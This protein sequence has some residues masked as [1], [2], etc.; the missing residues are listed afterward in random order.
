MATEKAVNAVLQALLP[1]LTLHDSAAVTRA[2]TSIRAAAPE[3]RVLANALYVFSKVVL[4]TPDSVACFNNVVN[5][6]VS[7]GILGHAELYDAID[8]ETHKL[9]EGAERGR[10]RHM[11]ERRMRTRTYY[12]QKR[13]NLF[14]EENE[15]YAKAIVLFWEVVFEHRTKGVVEALLALVGQFSLDSNRVIE[16][17]LMAAAEVVHENIKKSGALPSDH[18]LPQLFVELLDKF[19]RDH[20]A[21]VVGAM[22]LTHHAVEPVGFDAST[23]VSAAQSI[24]TV[25]PGGSALT[26]TRG[27]PERKTAESFLLLVLVLMREG[28]LTV[29]DIWHNMSPR[30]DRELV[31][32]FLVYEQQLER[33]S[34][35]VSSQNAARPMPIKDSSPIFVRTGIGASERDI[36]SQYK[37]VTAGPF[38]QYTCQKLEF[39]V[40]LINACRWDDAMDAILSLGVNGK[41]ID[42]AAQ[43]A[44]GR[45]LASFV[46][47][48]LNPLLCKHFPG[49]YKENRAL[50]EAITKLGGRKNR[51][52]CPVQSIEEFLDEN[53]IDGPGAVVLQMLQVLGPHARTSPGL[54]HALCRILR[55]E[56]RRK[57][58]AVTIMQEVVLPASSLLQSN[59]GLVNEIWE[60][61]RHWSHADRWLLYGHLQNVVSRNCAAYQ[62]VSSRASYE[63]RYVLK[64]L[65]SE[66]HKQHL[67]VITKIT[68]GQS[69]PAFSAAVDRIQGYPPDAVTISPVVEACQDCSELAVDVLLYTIVDRM[70]DS[71]KSRL[72]EDG[73]NIA[74][75]YATLSLFL[76]LCLRKLR[77]SSMQIEGVLS[78][79]YNKLVLDQEALLI[80][81]LSDVIKCVADIEVE[82]NLTSKQI[83]AQAGGRMLQAVVS[84][85]WSRLQPDIK[86][87]GY[88]FDG[89][90]EREKRSAVAA[91]LSSFHDSGLYVYIA[92]AIAQLTRN[93]VYQED[94]RTMPLKLGANIVDRARS[95]L[96]QLTQFL[97]CDL[98]DSF[99]EERRRSNVWQPFRDIGLATL[100]TEMSVPTSSAVALFSPILSYLDECRVDEH[101][102]TH[103]ADRKANEIDID[104]KTNPS[105]AKKAGVENSNIQGSAGSG[106]GSSRQYK[107]GD[108]DVEMEAGE[109]DPRTIDALGDQMKHNSDAK[110]SEGASVA[111]FANIIASRTRGLVTPQFIKTFW[112]LKLDDIALP[113]NL[114]ETEY[115]RLKT[116]KATWEKE[117]ER[118]R[119]HNQNDSERKRRCEAEY[120]RIREFLDALDVEKKSYMIKQASVRE[121]LRANS[122]TLYLSGDIQLESK[123]QETVHF[124]LQECIFPRCKVSSCDAI[125]CARFVLLL[126]ELDVPIFSHSMYYRSL[127]KLIPTVLSS[128]SEDEAISIARLVKEVLTVFE[129][130]R[131]N[132][133]IFDSEASSTKKH[134]FRDYENS[135]LKPLRH[136]QYC[137]WLFDIHEDLTEGLCVVLASEEYLYSRNSLCVLAGIADVFPKVSEHSA[138][139]EECVQKLC[140]SE[141]PDIRLSSTGVLARLKSGKAKRLP[142]HIFKLKPSSG[143]PT[144]NIAN[145]KRSG[146][147]LSNPVSQSRAQSTAVKAAESS[148]DY[149]KS[150]SNSL[151]E[152]PKVDNESTEVA[153]P[154]NTRSQAEQTKL[155]LN[156]N[157]N[158]FVPASCE[159]DSATQEKMT[160][161][162]KLTKRTRENG[163]GLQEQG[164]SENPNT[165]NR[166]KATSS[167][168]PPPSKKLKSGDHR[169]SNDDLRQ[170]VARPDAHNSVTL[171]RESS[172]GGLGA[173]K[174]S[175]HVT[176]ELS[177]QQKNSQ[178]AGSQPSCQ[179]GIREGL[180][181]ESSSRHDHS[182]S[183]RDAKRD[184]TGENVSYFP[185]S[186]SDIANRN[187]PVRSKS[188]R[189]DHNREG[190]DAAG[191][192]GANHAVLGD[193]GPRNT[194]TSRNGPNREIPSRSP[195]SREHGGRDFSRDMPARSPGEREQGVN[196]PGRDV[197]TRSPA[198]REQGDR[199]S[200]RD[201]SRRDSISRDDQT[202]EQYTREQPG[203]D[204]V[205]RE[206]VRRERGEVRRE[207]EEARRDREGIRREPTN[208]DVI[209]SGRDGHGRDTHGR[210]ITRQE[211]PGR[212][213]Q[214]HGSNRDLSSRELNGNTGKDAG[215]RRRGAG[216][217]SPYQHNVPSEPAVLGHDG[218]GHEESHG[219]AHGVKRRRE[220]SNPRGPYGFEGDSRRP[221]RIRS[222]ETSFRE[223]GGQRDEGVSRRFN[224]EQTPPLREASRF[225]AGLAGPPPKS[226]GWGDQRSRGHEGLHEVRLSSGGSRRREHESEV[227]MTWKVRQDERVE[228]EE[229]DRQLSRGRDDARGDNDYAR[230][231]DYEGFDDRGG[232]RSGDLRFRERRNGGRD[233]RRDRHHGRRNH[234]R[235]GHR[236]RG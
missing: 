190:R 123:M 2:I 13:F 168:M 16:L 59:V 60:V 39:I 52:P 119:R 47:A 152:K 172:T 187:P 58:R 6:L 81:T 179:A 134:G 186:I 229:R 157:A 57:A 33:L 209:S 115:E 199:E 125:F 223:R 170:G 234:G 24:A 160:S 7:S 211:S 210:N 21:S 11:E 104:M 221:S 196:E 56:R 23:N 122:A 226:G 41:H 5:A 180:D 166:S 14:R 62:V 232:N 197:P 175:E 236:R 146:G 194:T 137:E 34:K 105:I 216:S 227:G 127:L 50:T 85:V 54:L 82:S 120:R 118:N 78:F 100:V 202:R 102:Q 162:G 51:C 213:M 135:V 158:E 107:S 90:M 1:L 64:R 138:K 84:G 79:L 151:Q 128:S 99:R 101:M 159:N 31:N 96:L 156:P 61:L 212:N 178:S 25:S 177:S 182:L 132:R 3:S 97:Q 195:L 37:Y 117:V 55:L 154:K 139:I 145:G 200:G 228:L 10:E 169:R 80:T 113:I 111:A 148:T 65:T 9:L 27:E 144:V 155:P 193:D 69:L 191:R 206:E 72:K 164:E 77:V 19:Q 214:R 142:K 83:E 108:D 53:D 176:N 131:S 15:G 231:G 207:R 110:A 161:G 167:D 124:V 208:R 67:A 181:R 114:Y 106:D 198:G 36:F 136:E 147:T 163:P 4:N 66:T 98:V 48:L 149:P 103:H 49:L 88:A 218:V 192:N 143:G 42:I 224:G 29:H 43:P 188:S 30:D 204:A 225:E 95:S 91:L 26:P 233:D 32:M 184:T 150:K 12:T 93:S 75:W 17:T 40:L 63:M 45:A 76:G 220:L 171:D 109:I 70:A 183:N 35:H 126:M 203:R 205:R 133:D 73:I 173:S 185:D 153:T 141:L 217:H 116:I 222:E 130:W 215:R 18:R 38:E 86:L 129:K 28:R 165:G 219:D 201:P 8:Y 112:T 189:N 68:H 46:E 174:P 44:I 92:I 71:R 235:G 22:M 74:Q 87:V 89:K 20:V 121:V 230:D 94:L 140:D